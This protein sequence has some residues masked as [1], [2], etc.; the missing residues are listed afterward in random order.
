VLHLAKENFSGDNLHNKFLSN[1]QREVG[2]DSSFKISISDVVF[3][4]IIS[5]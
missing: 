3:S 4:D 2:V 5:L 1:L